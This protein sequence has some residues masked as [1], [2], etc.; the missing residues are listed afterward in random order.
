[1]I[2]LVIAMVVIGYTAGVYANGKPQEAQIFGQ[3]Q[4]Q[5]QAQLQAQ[6]QLQGQQQGQGQDQTQN[7]AQD[8]ANSQSTTVTTPRQRSKVKI[9]NVPSVSAPGIHSSNPCVVGSSGGVAAAG[10]GI[11]GGK[12]KIDEDC[13]KRELTRI[14]F[15]AGMNNRGVYMWCEQAA[16]IGTWDSIESCLTFEALTAEEYEEL[17]KIERARYERDTGHLSDMLNEATKPK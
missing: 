6:G 4:I 17:L 12:Q 10:F 13:V 1:M 9:N 5:D 14:A 8:Q 3:D 15:A 7:N 11:S 2:R 16:S